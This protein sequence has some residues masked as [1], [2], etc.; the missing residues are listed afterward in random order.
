VLLSRSAGAEIQR[1]LAAV[2]VGGIFTAGVLSLLLLPLLFAQIEAA[3]ERRAI[4]LSLVVGTTLLVIKFIAYYLTGSAA[5]FSDALESIVN[6]AASGVAAWSLY[7]A[8]QPPDPS[9]SQRC[10]GS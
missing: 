9:P 7:L 8:H 5:I 1:P 2:V 6:V 10:A 3:A 4:L